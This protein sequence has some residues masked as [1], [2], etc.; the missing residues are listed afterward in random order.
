MVSGVNVTTVSRAPFQLGFRSLIPSFAAQTCVSVTDPPQKNG[1]R[2]LRPFTVNNGSD[3]G[4]NDYPLNTIQSGK[5][6]EEQ[7]RD[8]SAGLV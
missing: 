3:D 8:K 4:L 2:T 6:A 7:L 1:H 5:L